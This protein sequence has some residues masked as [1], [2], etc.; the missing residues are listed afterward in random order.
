MYLS[1]LLRSLDGLTNIRSIKEIGPYVIRSVLHKGGMAYVLK[2][3]PKALP[4]EHV[5]LKVSRSVNDLHFDVA[6][7][8]E[9]EILRH[10]QHTNIVQILPVSRSPKREIFVARALEVKGQPWFLVMEYLSGGSLEEYLCKLKQLDWRDAARIAYRVALAL[11]YIHSEGFAHNDV[12]P[13]NIL[14]RQKLRASYWP[15]PVMIDFGIA[16]KVKKKKLDALTIVYAP[17]ERV[18]LMWGIEPLT[19]TIHLPNADVYSLSV[20]LYRMVVGKLPFDGLSERAVIEAILHRTPPQPRSI[21]KELPEKVDS[22]I[23]SSL[24]KSPQARPTATE[25]VAVL[26]EFVM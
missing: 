7:K 19:E 14:F 11:E 20:V 1:N 8:S 18:R 26:E 3:S 16:A 6:I 4:K 9:A 24:D 21:C 12:K 25:V 17:P 15:D 2:A 22:L 5:V 23:M 10:F 13:Q